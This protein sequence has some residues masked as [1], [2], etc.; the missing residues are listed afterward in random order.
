[1]KYL[2]NNTEINEVKT[3]FKTFEDNE[4]ITN[5]YEEI[6][7][8]HSKD[9][10]KE[11]FDSKGLY[12]GILKILD[13]D[14]ED[15]EFKE[16]ANKYLFPKIKEE[17]IDKYLNNPYV[18]NI[19]LN[20]I[21]YASYKLSYESYQPYEIFV[22]K[23]LIIDQ[24]NYFKEIP[25]LSCFTKPFNYQTIKYKNTTWMSLIPHEINTMEK[26]IFEASGNVVV[27]GLGLGYFPYMV[28][29]KDSVNHI[30]I[31]EKDPKIIELFK[32]NI[33]PQFNNKKKINIIENDAFKYIN[34]NNK[35][36]YIFVDLWHDANDGI[37]TYIHFIKNESMSNKYFYWIEETLLCY[38]RRSLILMINEEINGSL[39][40]DYLKQSN[41]HD[42]LINALHFKLKDKE[43]TTYDD[44]KELLINDNLKKLLKE[45]D[46]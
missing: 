46:I 25:T 3:L 26:A 19:K 13:I 1:M 21:N 32:Q 35:Y 40:K 24:E 17:N 44:I 23:D 29:L 18:K 45:L 9:L 5:I 31:I 2:L 34:N 16:L 11:I 30:D 15:K 37:K 22:L 28:S 42:E 33:L 12:G 38:V 36:D 7:F 10:S 6:L 4:T 20:N 43:I 27:Y 39:D 14:G 41:F 8:L